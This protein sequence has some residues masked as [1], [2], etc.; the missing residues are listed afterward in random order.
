M[1][2]RIENAVDP[3]RQTTWL[4]SQLVIFQLYVP[5]QVKLSELQF[6]QLSENQNYMG[7]YI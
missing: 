6:P 1:G 3:E 5:D 4:K 2:H 7:K